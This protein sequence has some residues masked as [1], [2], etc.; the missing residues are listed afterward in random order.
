MLYFF[1][2]FVAPS[3]FFFI[4][5]VKQQVLYKCYIEVCRNHFLIVDC[6]ILDSFRLRKRRSMS[7][8]EYYF[9]FELILVVE[10]C[11]QFFCTD[12]STIVSAGKNK[13]FVFICVT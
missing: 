8:L 10:F 13:D 7:Q 1:S 3:L 9:L 5:K 11:K 12:T 4:T 2:D 6:L